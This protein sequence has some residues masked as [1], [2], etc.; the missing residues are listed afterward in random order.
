MLMEI[1]FVSLHSMFG[2]WPF[3]RVVNTSSLVLHQ[4]RPGNVMKP[5]AEISMLSRQGE[6]A[7]HRCNFSFHLGE[8]LKVIQPWV[9][10]T[11]HMKLK[12]LQR[13]STPCGKLPRNVPLG[14]SVGSA[15][16]LVYSHP[17]GSFCLWVWFFVLST[18]SE[19]SKASSLALVWSWFTIFRILVSTH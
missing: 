17:L 13:S 5:P 2:F 19:G 11:H 18:S 16:C 3:S 10:L 12:Y 14:I 9:F 7:D 15:V 8:P 4:P 1:Y 6:S